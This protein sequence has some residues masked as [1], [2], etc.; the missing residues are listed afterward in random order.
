MKLASEI[1]LIVGRNS[2][3]A[4]SL[5]LRLINQYPKVAGL[6]YGIKLRVLVGDFDKAATKT[7]EGVRVIEYPLGLV[8]SGLLQKSLV[9]VENLTDADF[10]K[11]VAN[12]VLME[13]EFRGVSLALE[14]Y[15]GGGNT[16]AEAYDNLKENTSR[17]CLCIVDSDI[18]A[19]LLGPG[20]T[21]KKVLK[22]DRDRPVVRAGSH[23]IGA[24]SI[25]NLIPFF[26]FEEAWRYDPNYSSKLSL[27]KVHYREG[28]WKYLQLKKNISCF[29]LRGAS[30]FQ[31][32]GLVR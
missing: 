14:G 3:S 6:A 19:P 1:L 10:Y 28:H 18:R 13:T 29:E 9:L 12:V 17:L 23:V 21:A 22:S 5:L 30:A 4:S 7:V 31:F 11:W 24:C 26:F 15:P 25:E 2:G 16:T 20:D 32:I 27:Y 8:N